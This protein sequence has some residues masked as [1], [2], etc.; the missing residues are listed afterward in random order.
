MSIELGHG[1]PFT[2]G[3]L[4]SSITSSTRVHEYMSWVRNTLLKAV[5]P[6]DSYQSINEYRVGTW[7]PL[8]K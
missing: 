1:T 2:N 8:L 6:E 4:D 7:H 3:L 5:G